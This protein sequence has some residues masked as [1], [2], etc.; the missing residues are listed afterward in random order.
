MKDGNW[1]QK[2]IDYE[3]MNEKRKRNEKESL[4]VLFFL[5]ETVS[6]KEKQR[7]ETNV[8]AKILKNRT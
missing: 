7:R 2:N 6:K 3:W 5:R 4:F 8:K 1:K